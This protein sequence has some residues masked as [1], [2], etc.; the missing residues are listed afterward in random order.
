VGI[1]LQVLQLLQE[2]I[3]IHAA[4]MYIQDGVPGGRGLL[5][6]LCRLPFFGILNLLKEGIL[7][8]PFLLPPVTQTLNLAAAFLDT[9]LRACL[10]LLC[11][12]DDAVLTA[13]RVKV[14][15]LRKRQPLLQPSLL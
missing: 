1:W 11:S 8:L 10:D 14:L 2:R 7:K 13:P 12:R 15:A 4:H 3:Y 9:V 5:L 6:E